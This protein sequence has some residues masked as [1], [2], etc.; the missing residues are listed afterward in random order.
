MRKPCV[1]IYASKSKLKV[2][3][4]NTYIGV[5]AVVQ[6]VRVLALLLCRYRV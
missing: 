5:P 3:L 1:F 2:K 4:K 6:Q